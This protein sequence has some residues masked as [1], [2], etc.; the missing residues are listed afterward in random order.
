MTGHPYLRKVNFYETDQ[1]GVVHHANY[2][3]WLEEAREDFLSGTCLQGDLLWNKGIRVPVISC[4]CTYKKPARYPSE[5]LIYTTLQSYNGLRFSFHYELRLK[6]SGKLAARGETS[7]CFVDERMK[8]I[9]IQRRY[10]EL[11]AEIRMLL[12]ENH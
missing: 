10:P 11:D 4:S 6:D 3:K 7:H 12:Q 8:P 9:H 1:L 2:L 5:V